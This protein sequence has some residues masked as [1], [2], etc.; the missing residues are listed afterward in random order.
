MKLFHSLVQIHLIFFFFFVHLCVFLDTYVFFS[1]ERVFYYPRIF[2]VR[3]LSTQPLPGLGHSFL[4]C[5]GS[6]T[7]HCYFQYPLFYKKMHL[8][9]KAICGLVINE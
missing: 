3:G 6:G 5:M 9:S 2:T 7:F 4:H 1:S 8:L